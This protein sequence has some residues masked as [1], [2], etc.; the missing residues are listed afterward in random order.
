[1]ITPE[2]GKTVRKGVLHQFVAR[3]RRGTDALFG[4]PAC[5]GSEKLTFAENCVGTADIPSHHRPTPGG[6]GCHLARAPRLYVGSTCIS[7]FEPQS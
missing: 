7:D 6:Q 4:F 2:T 1:M 3:S 5:P